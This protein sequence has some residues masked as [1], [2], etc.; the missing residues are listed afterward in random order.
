MLKMSSKR[1]RTQ[2][3]IKAEKEASAQK[4]MEAQTKL[5][6]LESLKL[7]VQQLQQENQTGKVAANLMSQFMEAGLVN[8]EDEGEFTVQPSQSPSKFKPFVTE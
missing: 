8:Q 7:Q 2:T 4:E 3:Q 5:A 1:R 6:E